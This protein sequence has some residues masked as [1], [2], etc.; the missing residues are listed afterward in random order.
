[1]ISLKNTFLLDGKKVTEVS[2]KLRKKNGY[3]EPENPFPLPRISFPF[4]VF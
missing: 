1:M 4:Y 3:H 2:E